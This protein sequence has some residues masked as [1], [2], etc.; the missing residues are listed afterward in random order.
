MTSADQRNFR[1]SHTWTYSDV[2]EMTVEGVRGL[3]R[4]ENGRI[5]VNPS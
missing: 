4:I 3:G 2:A 5:P 1:A